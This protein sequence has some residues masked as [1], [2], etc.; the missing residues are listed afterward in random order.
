MKKWVVLVFLTFIAVYTV[1]SADIPAPPPLST[2]PV[3]EQLYLQ[4]IYE[5]FNEL[6]KVT[7]NP[8]GNKKGDVGDMVIYEAPFLDYY[9]AINIDNLYHWQ[10]IKLEAIP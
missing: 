5:N 1:Y 7:T 3:A 6:Q 8:Y 2:E 10:G 4:S 9:F